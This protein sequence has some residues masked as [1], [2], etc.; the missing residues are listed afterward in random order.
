MNCWCFIRNKMAKN[1]PK[2]LRIFNLDA[3]NVPLDVC[4]ELLK[5]QFKTPNTKNGRTA[6]YDRPIST[7]EIV[8]LQPTYKRGNVFKLSEHVMFR[9]K[10]DR[11]LSALEIRRL[12]SL[13]DAK[14]E[15]A[16]VDGM[17]WVQFEHWKDIQ[18]GK[19]K[20]FSQ[21]INTTARDLPY[22]RFKAR[23]N[24]SF[25]NNS[26]KKLRFWNPFILSFFN[27]ILQNVKMRECSTSVF[28]VNYD[29]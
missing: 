5:L 11:K 2:T 19:C 18:C 3:T 8:I 24:R 1:W 23:D 7:V 6:P 16:E 4:Y 22:R 28:H 21:W 29:S 17:L 27:I 15:S 9:L 25:S 13:I 14:R 20:R 12:R 10:V 26:K